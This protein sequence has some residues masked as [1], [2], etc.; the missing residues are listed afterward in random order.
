E[1][2]HGE[3]DEAVG[4]SWLSFRLGGCSPERRA[5]SAC[6]V[7]D[8]PAGFV[9]GS[10]AVQ[11]RAWRR[12]AGPASSQTS[13]LAVQTV[14]RMAFHS[15]ANGTG[16][17]WTRMPSARAGPQN[18]AS[19]R[20]KPRQNDWPFRAMAPV[21]RSAA[22]ACGWT[23]CGDIHLA[24]PGQQRRGIPPSRCRRLTKEI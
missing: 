20:E 19:L 10:A 13:Q 12:E 9:P 24:D 4:S 5:T 2:D 16:A 15:R 6:Y 11:L 14:I 3:R 23:T 18:S 8:H 1:V 21:N 17:R 7:V 22:F